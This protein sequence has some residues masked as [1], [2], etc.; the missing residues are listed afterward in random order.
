M[1]RLILPAI[2][3]A[4]SACGPDTASAPPAQQGGLSEEAVAADAKAGDPADTLRAWANAMEA[5]NWE[6]A[7]QYWGENGEASGLSAEEYAEAHD[8]Y[9]TVDVTLEEGR[10]EGAAGTVYYEANVVMTGEI[11]D[12]EAYRMEGP[13]VLSRVN[14]VP[15]A[16]DEERQWHIETSDLRARPVD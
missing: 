10:Q 3:L 15:G 8:K 16:S 13:V 2:F 5:R 9:R 14:E 12:G 7:R 1:T 4:L 6:A 11:Q